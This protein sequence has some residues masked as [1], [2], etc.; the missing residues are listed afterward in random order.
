MFTYNYR[1]FDRHDRPIVSLAVLGDVHPDWRADGFGYRRWGCE[2]QLRFP[3]VKLLDFAWEK[4]EQSDNPFAVLVMSHRKAQE[5]AG[6][7]YS[8][9]RWK[10]ML[11]KRLY[12][13]G[14]Q[15]KDILELFRFI[16]W[17]L[18]LP[19]ALEDNLWQELQVYEET[20]RMT[21]I[22]SVERIGLEKG[23]EQGIQQGIQRGLMT[24]RQLLRRQIHRRFG[25]AVA[26]QSQPLLERIADSSVLEEIGELL[27]DSSSDAL[28]QFLRA[29]AEQ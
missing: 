8:R 27:L 9:Y 21:Y 10:L 7:A 22:T 12:E 23:L 16:D 19:R 4:L 28:L 25:E 13:R 3:V 2:M 6:D 29:H 5:T 20:N 14:Y 24:A 26:Q 15:R 17:L 1:L 11:V 18:Q